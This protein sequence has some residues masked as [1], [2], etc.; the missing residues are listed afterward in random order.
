[1]TLR[2]F[3]KFGRIPKLRECAAIFGLSGVLAKEER[4]ESD[5]RQVADG[6]AAE[7]CWRFIKSF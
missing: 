4:N 6:S 2:S 3:A 1:M 5:R 7:L